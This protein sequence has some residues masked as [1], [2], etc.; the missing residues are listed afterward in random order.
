MRKLIILI[1]V[2]IAVVS[3]SY[4]SFPIVEMT[5]E[6]NIEI[7]DDTA[8]KGGLFFAV[9]SV[10][11]SLLSVLFIFLFI[12]NGFAHNGN[13]YPYLLLSIIS[14]IGTISSAL[15]AKKRSL[16]SS[17]SFIGISILIVSLLLIMSLFFI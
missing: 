13:P 15:Q 7:V 4:S 9:L 10:A 5:Q 12:G 3:T 16:K 2:S 1:C 8:D 17:K 6:R 14:I 11:L